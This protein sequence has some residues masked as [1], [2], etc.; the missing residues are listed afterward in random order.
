VIDRLQTDSQ[1]G[2]RLDNASRR[3]RQQIYERAQPRRRQVHLSSH[4][5]PASFV[6][7]RNTLS[8]HVQDALNE[9]LP[10]SVLC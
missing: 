5:R 9:R 7:I 6:S 3:N 4:Q 8:C 1:P 10:A 2:R